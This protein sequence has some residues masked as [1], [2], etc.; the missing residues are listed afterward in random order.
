MEE[1]KERDDL[2]ERFQDCVVEK[3][4][5]LEDIFSRILAIKNLDDAELSFDDLE[6]CFKV[7]KFK[8]SKEKFERF[9]AIMIQNDEGKLMVRDFLKERRQKKAGN[10]GKKRNFFCKFEEICN[11]IGSIISN[12]NL[13]DFGRLLKG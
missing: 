12:E 7:M 2:I 6:N 10:M 3:G 1:F 9:A 5:K 11:Y 4:M 8:V 13:T